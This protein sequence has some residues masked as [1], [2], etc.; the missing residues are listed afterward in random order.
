LE[1]HRDPGQGL[2]TR[3]VAE[4]LRPSEFPRSAGYEAQRVRIDGRRDVGFTRLVARRSG[5][6]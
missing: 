4:K 3:L 6:G 5:R 1:L 2:Y